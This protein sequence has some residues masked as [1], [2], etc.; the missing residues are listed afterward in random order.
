MKFPTEANKRRYCRAL[1]PGSPTPGPDGRFSSL[2][3]SEDRDREGS[4]G[5]VPRL[6]S[7]VRRAAHGFLQA[8]RERVVLRASSS[9]QEFA[10]DRSWVFQRSAFLDGCGVHVEDNFSSCLASCPASLPEVVSKT[11]ATWTIRPAAT[12]FQTFRDSRRAELV[13]DSSQLGGPRE[14]IVPILLHLPTPTRLILLV[15]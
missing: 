13:P 1:R 2:G 4:I 5:C 7:R 11:K 6:R 10:K 8:R 9:P 12:F 15:Y 3:N 14:P